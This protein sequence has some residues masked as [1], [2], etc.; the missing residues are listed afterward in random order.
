[1]TKFARCTFAGA[2]LG[3]PN[4]ALAG[5]VKGI[6]G[7]DL[8]YCRE[9]FEYS[10]YRG[11]SGQLALNHTS[12]PA[13][14]G[15]QYANG[16]RLCGRCA[17]DYSMDGLSGRCKKCPDSV[18][19]VVIAVT[20]VLAGLIFLVGL[21]QLTLLGGGD[22]DSSDGA[23]SIGM[24]FIQLI[25]LLRNFPVAWPKIFTDLFQIGGAITALGQHLVNL[26]CLY[27]D[28]SEADVFYRLKI[29]WAVAPP[30]LLVLCLFTW[31][32][33]D[34]IYGVM[35][36]SPTHPK[37]YFRL[38]CCFPVT[39]LKMKV[40]TSNVV[41]LY[42]IWPSLCS[43]TFSLFACRSTICNNDETYLRADLNEV[44]W[45]QGSR[46]ANYAYLLG[47]PML[48]LY[49]IGLPIGAL[50]RVWRV[51]LAARSQ[52]LAQ[53][54]RRTS[55]HYDKETVG[56]DHKIY[57]MFFSAFR[58]NKWWWEFTIAGRKIGIALIGVFGASMNSMQV[59][60][61]LMMV[62]VIML[63]TAHVQPFGG[64]YREMLHKLEMASLMATFLTLWAAS[65]FNVHPKCQDTL[66]WCDFLS[67]TVG[68]LDFSFILVVVGCFAWLKMYQEK[69][70]VVSVV[71][72]FFHVTRSS[73]PNESE[74]T[75]PVAIEMPHMPET[76]L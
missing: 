67:V 48:L 14:C 15:E 44:C 55:F 63:V 26:K 25:A 23:K 31:Y 5:K 71:N 27:P 8:A 75:S 2:C 16:S 32:F 42:L 35:K 37:R 22:L 13:K 60:F 62:V 49:V 9:E 21:I 38:P 17:F 56:E 18:Q 50:M 10:Y 19:N 54:K 41:L 74:S 64:V 3:G 70:T 39:E 53:R 58:E 43:E 24:S 52:S 68:I 66:R 46:H 73:Q 6:N 1:M 30:V 69:N 20:G 28:M 59:H 65:I 51:Q 34:W 40:K 7:K 61:T 57:G 33:V 47:V 36:C 11:L 29:L 4:P 12:C 72:P 76:T 45:Q